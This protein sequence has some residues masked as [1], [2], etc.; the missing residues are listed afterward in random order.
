[1]DIRNMNWIPTLSKS[2]FRIPNSKI[3]EIL[4][5]KNKNENPFSIRR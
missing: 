1:M 4:S 3:E 5:K 2:A